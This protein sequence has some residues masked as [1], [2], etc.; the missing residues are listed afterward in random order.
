MTLVLRF[1]VRM[2]PVSRGRSISRLG[3]WFWRQLGA[4]PIEE[5]AREGGEADNASQVLLGVAWNRDK[6]G[7]DGFVEYDRD[8]VMRRE[9][10]VPRS[11]LFPLPL[12]VRMVESAVAV[13]SP[14]DT[15]ERQL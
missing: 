8:G 2:L 5:G 1:R 13:V 14:G 9:A 7:R 15:R 6:G 3:R 12:D 10:A 11:S 4:V